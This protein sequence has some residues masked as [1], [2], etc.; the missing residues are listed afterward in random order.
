MFLSLFLSSFLPAFLF[1]CLPSF[2][3]LFL[4]FL[5][6]AF[7]PFFLPSGLLSFLTLLLPCF[8]SL[9]LVSFCLSFF[10]SSGLPSFLSSSFASFSLGFF[11]RKPEKYTRKA[12]TCHWSSLMVVM[13]LKEP[14][15]KTRP[16]P[17]K[18]MCKASVQVHRHHC[19]CP[20]TLNAKPFNPEPWARKP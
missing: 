7:L 13:L 8:L 18:P 1:C 17:K 2:V 10:L 9:F 3:S 11:G 14:N 5:V 4:W 15:C 20:E 6:S 19:S 16:S 12:Q